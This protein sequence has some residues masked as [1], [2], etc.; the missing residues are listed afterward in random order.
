[1]RVGRAGVPLL[2]VLPTNSFDVFVKT[3][4]QRDV[5]RQDEFSEAVAG[6]ARR[7]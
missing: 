4:E 7:L 6:P 3:L 2:R 5:L 1:M